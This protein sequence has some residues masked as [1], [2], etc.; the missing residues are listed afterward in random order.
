MPPNTVSDTHVDRMCVRVALV[1]PTFNGEVDGQYEYFDL[2]VPFAWT[3]GL[4][5]A[6]MDELRGRLGQ[7][8]N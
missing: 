2:P 3:R 1:I 7:L 8:H 5:W 6:P 4:P